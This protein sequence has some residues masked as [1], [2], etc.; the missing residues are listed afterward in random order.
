MM[1][2]GLPVQMPARAEEHH[3]TSLGNPA[4][5]FA[6]PLKTPADLR[7]RFA[8]PVLKPDF[9]SVLRQWRWVGDPEDLHRAAATAEIR[10]HEIPVDGVMPFMRS[11]E[12]RVG[13]ECA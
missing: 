6:P 13:K 11:E 4:T 12:R 3:A 7:A 8:D 1:G 9:A 10:E 5:R 2:L